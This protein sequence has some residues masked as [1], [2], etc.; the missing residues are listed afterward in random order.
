M[1][2]EE[3]PQHTCRDEKFASAPQ[4]PPTPGA[5][6]PDAVVYDGNAHAGTSF[7]GAAR[8]I[9]ARGRGLQTR[10][11]NPYV[12]PVSRSRAP[13]LLFVPSNLPPQV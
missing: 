11:P 9:R 4:Q 12:P 8:T 6:P 3:E 7:A 5:P 1:D 2:D 13:R 10:T